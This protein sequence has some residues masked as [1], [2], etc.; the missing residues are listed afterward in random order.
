[1]NMS[2]SHT[3]VP[4]DGPART[5]RRR[6]RSRALPISLVVV[7]ATAGMAALVPTAASFAR[8]PSV[9]ILSANTATTPSD[10]TVSV[11]SVMGSGCPQGSAAVAMSPD[12]TA[13]TVTYSKYL[14]QVGVGTSPTDRRRNCQLNV[15]VNMP[16]GFTYA[17]DQVDY[18]GYGH[19][20]QG[21]SGE[22]RASYYFQ[23]MTETVSSAHPFTGPLDDN[24]QATDKVGLEAM[25]FAP[26]G[27]QRNLNINTQLKVNAG[28]SD[29]ANTTSFMSMDSTDSAV[30]AVYHFAWKKCQA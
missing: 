4:E 24:W 1:M 26:C 17:I 21:A 5:G 11:A 27:E 10:V 3:H 28:A 9:S 7:A 22:A 13:F 14:A 15:I 16:G 19:L 6:F 23:G 18:R 2:Q 8:T 25:V 29:L 30:S 12:N 20:E